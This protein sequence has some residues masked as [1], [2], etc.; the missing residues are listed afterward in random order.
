MINLS[1]LS[2]DEIDD[3][4]Y[5][6]Q[7]RHDVKLPLHVDLRNYY[8]VI[9]NQLQ[10]G[11]CTAESTCESCQMFCHSE[12]SKIFNYYTSRKLLG[13]TGDSGSTLRSAVKSANKFG[14]PDENL[15]PYD[16]TKI[17]TEPPDFVYQNALK[18]RI[19]EYHRILT[20]DA[21]K[22]EIDYQVRFAL[23]EGYPVLISAKV[24]IQLENLQSGMIYSPL[25]TPGNTYWGNHAMLIVGY[26]YQAPFYYI[27]KNSW[28]P[29]W[30]ENGYFRASV[31]MITDDVQDLWV[32]KGFGLVTKVGPDQTI[33]PP[34]P[35]SVSIKMFIDGHQNDPQVIIDSANLYEINATDIETALGKEKGW[36]KNY[37]I[38]DNIGK[39]LN[40]VG[41]DWS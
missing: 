37:S 39:T 21:E 17:D 26:N 15:W 5:I 9:E 14:I 36:L 2:P 8:P 1:N 32:V 35:S 27:V 22:P 10:I 4:D 19:T 40:W 6:Y 41:F 34:K 24:G 38:N 30:C 25:S 3:R 13:L 20:L 16:T 28:G 12:K 18:S 7:V 11:S 23:A 31:S 33:K 29:Q